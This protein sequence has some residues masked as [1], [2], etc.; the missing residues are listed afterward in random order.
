MANQKARKKS[1]K[2]KAW[3]IPVRCIFSKENVAVEY[4]KS[5]CTMSSVWGIHIGNY[6]HLF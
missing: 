6:R 4:I 2:I 5:Y 1:G 3:E